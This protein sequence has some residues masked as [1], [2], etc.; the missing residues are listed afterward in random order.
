MAIS[1]TVPDINFLGDATEKGTGKKIDYFVRLG[2]TSFYTVAWVG[3][4]RNSPPTA[5]QRKGITTQPHIV[6]PQ[7]QKQK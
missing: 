7:P 4:A 2:E 3:S 5:A 6:S 1:T